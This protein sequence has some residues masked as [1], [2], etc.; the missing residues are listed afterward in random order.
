MRSSNWIFR[1]LM[2]KKRIMREAGIDISELEVW[3]DGKDPEKRISEA[4]KKA[5]LTM[6]N[7]NNRGIA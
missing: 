5:G 3:K 4:F 2:I 7:M 1:D 6:P